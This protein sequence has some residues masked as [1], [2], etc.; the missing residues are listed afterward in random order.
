MS[1]HLSPEDFFEFI[2]QG[3]GSGPAGRH[4]SRWSH[5][6]VRLKKKHAPFPRTQPD[7]AR[8]HGSW[9]ESL[10]HIF[11]SDLREFIEDRLLL[12]RRGSP[13]PRL[14][15]APRDCGGRSTPRLNGCLRSG[16]YSSSLILCCRPPEAR[17]GAARTFRTRSWESGCVEKCAPTWRRSVKN[18]T[19]LSVRASACISS[20]PCRRRWVKRA[21]YIS[22]P[23]VSRSCYSQGSR[24][25]LRKFLR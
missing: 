1:E 23:K 22:M 18:A 21:F 20:T 25:S 12:S 4:V 17:G 5:L 24:P 7:H 9:P 13:S 10:Q 2:D 3:G 15:A 16:C 11:G 8:P 19:G 14:S 6:V